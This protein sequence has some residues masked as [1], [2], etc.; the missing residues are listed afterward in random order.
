MNFKDF[1]KVDVTATHTVFKHPSGHTIHVA[2]D[3]LTPEQKKQMRE[4]PIQ[5]AME[6]LRERKKA[7]KQMAEGGKVEVEDED[8]FEKLQSE[9]QAAKEMPMPGEVSMSQMPVQ[10]GKEISI[11]DA[12][13]LKGTLTDVPVPGAAEELAVAQA[14]EPKETL[15]N[16]ELGVPPTEKQAQ[17]AGAPSMGS[18]I[19][20]EGALQQIEGAKDIAEAQKAKSLAETEALGKSLQQ[21]QQSLTAVQ[22]QRQQIQSNIDRLT[23]AV[24]EGTLKPD[25]VLGSGSN[26][27]MNVIGLVLGGAMQFATLGIVP[28]LVKQAIDDDIEKQKSELEQRNNLLGYNLKL[29]GNIN[30]AENVTRMQ[31]ATIADL[32]AKRAALKSA[33][34]E[35]MGRYQIFSGELQS[36]LIAPYM[37]QMEQQA[38]MQQASSGPITSPTQIVQMIESRIPKGSRRAAIQ[39]YSKY[40]QTMSDINQ[41]RNIMQQQAEL[42]TLAKRLGSPLQTP[43]LLAAKKAQL[44]PVIKGIIGEKMTDADVKQMVDPFL[45]SITTSPETVNQL[46]DELVSTIMSRAG[47]IT[48]TLELYD[49]KLP[50]PIQAK[51]IGT[52]KRK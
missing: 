31:M 18:A 33:D 16:I 50:K 32:Q 38:A 8:A 6:K 51:P 26:K 34:K 14:A 35:A 41:V 17:V 10:K 47:S 48:P 3:S 45:V 40:K 13:L 21:M 15:Q 1:K 29:L 24:E 43:K 52:I 30:D 46:T 25:R 27:V 28:N 44:F 22:Q 36:K 19:A 4:I 39:E 12:R 37:Q 2:H 11:P 49:I 42:N 20:I 5:S 23:K 7:A 9:M